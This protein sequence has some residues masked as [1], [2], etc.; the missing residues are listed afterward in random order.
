MDP[1]HLRVK[2]GAG[3][4]QRPTAL[5]EPACW[6]GPRPYR[7]RRPEKTA[8][9]RIVAA[10]LETFLEQGRQRT[11]HGFGYPRFIENSFRR[12]LSCGI[13]SE[14][15]ARVACRQCGDEFLLAFSCKTRGVCPS[16]SAR[17]M[18]ETAAVL[19]DNLLPEAG[20]RQWVLSVPFHLRFLLARDSDILNRVLSIF[21]RAIFASQRRRARKL[22]LHSPKTGA[23]TFVQR[24]GGILNLNIHFHSLI[25]DGVFVPTHDGSLVFVALAPPNDHDV[26]VVTCRVRRRVQS[27]LAKLAD[28]TDLDMTDDDRAALDA[29]LAEALRPPVTLPP[30]MDEPWEHPMRRKQRCALD[31]GYSV[32]ANAAVDPLDRKG[33]EKLCR[34]GMRSSFAQSRLS[35]SRDGQVRYELKKPWP[36]PAGVTEL[37][38][39]PV[40]F[41]RRLACLIPPPRAHMVRYHGVLAP[42]ARARPLL[43]RPPPCPNMALALPAAGDDASPASDP[44]QDAP[45]RLGSLRWAQMVQRVWQS[46]V[47]TCNRCQGRRRIIAFVTA[48][49]VI[50]KILGHLGL[51]VSKPKVAPARGPPQTDFLDDDWFDD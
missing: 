25:P 40:A 41:L 17:R 28:R 22:S 26:W 5:A 2:A 33:L 16:C 1:A 14:G 35:L 18:H 3:G 42:N 31:Q 36:T 20:Y 29:A 23:V 10:H 48:P 49:E 51:P 30:P 11:D 12:Y 15:F 7:Q 27:L 4:H 46:D 13:W 8:L 50:A 39:D 21:L 9:Y 38:L 24:F 32:H 47:L 34:Y 43:P 6:P 44:T 19:V 37:R 45:Q